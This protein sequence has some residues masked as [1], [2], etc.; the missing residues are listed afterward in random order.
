MATE[1][2]KCLIHKTKQE[3]KIRENFQN[4]FYTL[5]IEL[6]MADSMRLYKDVNVSCQCTE[7]YKKFDELK[8]YF[9]AMKD[10]SVV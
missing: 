7:N 8:A 9:L 5:L 3:G 10:E 6:S 4:E 1:T 2:Y